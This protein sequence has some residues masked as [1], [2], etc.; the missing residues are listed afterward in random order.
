MRKRIK[1]SVLLVRKTAKRLV[2]L[3]SYLGVALEVVFALEVIFTREV[4]IC[5]RS[6]NAHLK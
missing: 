6:N 4:V 2:R 1:Q 5:A 3:F